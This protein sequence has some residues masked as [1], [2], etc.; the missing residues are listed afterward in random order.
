M[1]TSTL[2][3]GLLIALALLFSNLPWLNERL[4]AV[5][6]LKAGIKP[7]PVRLLEWCAGV[8]L[9]ALVAWRVEM[10]CL[11]NVGAFL[12]FSDCPGDVHP[13]SWEFYTV[14]LVLYA[15]LALPGFIYFVE[16]RRRKREQALADA[17]RD[18]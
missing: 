17:G 11:P 5:I 3:I 15:V 1:M 14:T 7:L 12:G 16:F 4:F 9:V 6:A 18:S 10:G 2:D 8:L 13:K